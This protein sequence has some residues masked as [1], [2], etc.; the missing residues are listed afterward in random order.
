[1]NLTEETKI[2]KIVCLVLINHTPIALET[3]Y[4]LREL[5][6]N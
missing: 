4:L 6:L 3:S 2:Y 5:F 1:M